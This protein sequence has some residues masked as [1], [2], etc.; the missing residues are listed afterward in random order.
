V[1]VSK[2]EFEGVTFDASDTLPSELAQREGEPLDPDKVRESTR[3]LFDSGRYRAVM[4]RGV[5]QGD[6]MTLI[7]SGTPRFYVGRITNASHRC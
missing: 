3:R 1:R 7:F 4:V 5:R 6:S 2:I